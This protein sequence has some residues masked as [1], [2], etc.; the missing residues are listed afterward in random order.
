LAH[1]L[2]G[3]P[4][5]ANVVTKTAL[6]GVTINLSKMEQIKEY[7]LWGEDEKN[8]VWYDYQVNSML[9]IPLKDSGEQVLGILQLINARDPD[10][11]AKVDFDENLQ[12][13]MES[14]SSLAVAALEAYTREFNLKQ[15]IQQLRI[16]IDEAKQKQ[17]LK[18]IVD[19][20]FFQNLTSRAKD[21]REKRKLGQG[22]ADK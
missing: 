22:G 13:M 17:Q 8:Q 12:Q 6:G 9:T 10:T 3:G 19:T 16:E 11:S 7:D 4:N 21:L 15:E 14:F 1:P 20:D 5:T 18:E 2:N